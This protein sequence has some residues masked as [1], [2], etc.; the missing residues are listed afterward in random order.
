MLTVRR[1]TPFTIRCD[2]DGLDTVSYRCLVNGAVAVEE[3]ASELI[4]GSIDFAFPSGL[5]KGVY[6]TSFIAIN[7]LDEV[8]DPLNDTL[9]VQSQRPHA[10]INDRLV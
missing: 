5:P 9:I 10:L 8:S 1:N 6:T 4:N 2:H 7:E 3:P